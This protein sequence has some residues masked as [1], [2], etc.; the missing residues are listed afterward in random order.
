MLN[1]FENLLEIIKSHPHGISINE[2]L[3]CIKAIPKRT[4]QYQL[5]TLVKSRILK[6]EGT[7]RS[8][9]YY[10]NKLISPTFVTTFDV[11]GQPDPFR[12]RYRESIQQAIHTVVQHKLDKLKSSQFIS[13][14]AHENISPEDR[15]RFIE[16]VEV[17]VSS[18]HEG[19]F[20]RFKIRPSE[21]FEWHSTWK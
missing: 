18:L 12:I 17:E 9:K 16:T 13:K 15:S 20:A 1:K 6:I 8:R 4:L 19:N 10:I 2:L 11:P 5:T 21:F 14:F 3:H 7:S